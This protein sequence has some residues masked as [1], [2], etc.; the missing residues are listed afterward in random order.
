[1]CVSVDALPPISGG[2]VQGRIL[3][4]GVRCICPVAQAAVTMTMDDVMLGTDTSDSAGLFSLA[5]PIRRKILYRV[6][7]SHRDYK[8]IDTLITSDSAG[9][10]NLS[11]SLWRKPE[12]DTTIGPEWLSIGYPQQWYFI[13]APTPAGY[14]GT[15]YAD[16]GNKTT[17]WNLYS[18][19]IDAGAFDGKL[20]KVRGQLELNAAAQPYKATALAPE[21]RFLVAQAALAEKGRTVINY[22]RTNG[23][24]SPQYAFINTLSIDEAGHVIYTENDCIMC[25]RLVL[26]KV[27]TTI[28]NSRLNALI[29][30]FN[31]NGF[32]RLDTML[33]ALPP[34]G[35]P[36]ITL[37]CD[38]IIRQVV[39][40]N[41]QE[42][43]IIDGLDAF[44][45]EITTPAAIRTSASSVA[46]SSGHAYRKG[47]S[48]HFAVIGEGPTQISLYDLSGRL[49]RE[50]RPSL[51]SI[52]IPARELRPGVYMARV[53][54]GSHKTISRFAVV[55]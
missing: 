29:D 42:Q 8:G 9:N 52:T 2:I 10:A 7:V 41:K 15:L 16:A 6:S 36:S 18:A 17:L 48:I 30:L 53:I 31:K 21:P 23:T 37:A 13:Q 32:W 55:P 28:G 24:V 35:A 11:F 4:A 25:E 39:S 54:Q 44:I 40:A 46:G 20:T 19:T 3:Q 38:G 45:K 33:H 50:Y 22:V 43:A 34:I 5:T 49:L 26:P 51:S 14:Y 47:G 12:I 27:D 1:L